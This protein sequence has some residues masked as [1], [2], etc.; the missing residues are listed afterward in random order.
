MSLGNG[1]QRLQASNLPIFRWERGAAV[2]FYTP[3]GLA[4]VPAGMAENFQSQTTGD[5]RSRQGAA[6]WL[7]QRAVQ[8]QR[9]WSEISARPYAPTCL[10]L[11]L[12]NACNLACTYCYSATQTGPADHLTLATIRDAA[13]IVA[14][15]CQRQGL[16]FTAVFHGGGEP[17]LYPAE[18]DAA[19]DLLE[20]IAADNGLAIFR[21]IATNGVL[22]PER[23]AWLARR[24]DLIGISCDGPSEIQ[25]QQRLHPQG[26]DAPQMIEQTANIIHQAGKPLHV[27]VTLTPA[28]FR[29][30]P[31]IAAYISEELRPQEIHVE[32]V[33][34]AGRVKSGD[35]FTPEQADEFVGAFLEARSI[36]QYYSI[37]W[38]TSGSRPW[39]VHG[40]Y[41]QVFRNVLHLIPGSAA[42]A[43]FKTIDAG[44]A[45]QQHLAIAVSAAT[46]AILSL[47]RPTF[48]HCA[49]PCWRKRRNAR[50]AS[51]DTT[52]SE[53]AR[54]FVRPRARPPRQ[55]FAAGCSAA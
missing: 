22:R 33:Y 32:P 7:Y 18:V 23:A 14:E 54:I 46:R 31:E 17:T 9:A 55:V 13:R 29:R 49:G 12:H 47:T 43:C 2:W 34:R 45:D 52:A 21:Y 19:L 8:A 28:S 4:V 35:C 50:P 25:N 39:E 26:L 1:F 11:Y 38:L 6:A 51:I 37:P 10:T 24:F 30:Q 40:P 16:P 15:N 36:A 5:P 53:S 44:Q 27:R 48:N 41:C 20:G 42:T 3:G